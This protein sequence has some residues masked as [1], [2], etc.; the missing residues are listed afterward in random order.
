MKIITGF[1]FLFFSFVIIAQ[2]PVAWGGVTPLSQGKD[3]KTQFPNLLSLESR[4]TLFY[5]Y[6]QSLEKSFPLSLQSSNAEGRT[7]S[8][9]VGFDKERVTGG[10]FGDNCLWQYN[11]SARVILFELEGMTVLQAHP[12]GRSRN[13]VDDPKNCSEE[14]RDKKRDRFRFCQILL[15][16]ETDSKYSQEEVM[17]SCEN[18][19]LDDLGNGM[20]KEVGNIVANLDISDKRNIRFAGIG[21]VNITDRAL[22][23]L[24]GKEGFVSHPFHSVGGQFDKQSY[25]DWISQY[26][27][28]AIS[29]KLDVPLVAPFAGGLGNS[30]FMTLEDGSDVVL[31]LPE[32][33]YSFDILIRGFA[34]SLVDETAQ[35]EAW[36][37]GSYLTVD[38]GGMIGKE[39]SKVKNGY[40]FK[41]VKD[42][43]LNDWREFD[44]SVQQLAQE[45][46]DQLIKTDKKWVP[47]HT[48]M[49]YKDGKKYF[50]YI[51]EKLD[52][53]K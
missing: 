13:Y 38:F 35:R 5:Q 19:Q 44:N 16:L 26:F 12:V 46:A 18:V 33:D 30:A 48:N 28:K 8:I 36:I 25:K 49:K 23:I 37:Y 31:T 6:V 7:K 50:S 32:L 17:K 34:K 45:Y 9:V 4:Y 24:S 2:E 29:T 10:K 42:D 3:Q 39:S 22:G 15:G 47:Q 40:V 43:F 27:V 21:D 41:T 53:A 20:I 51:K 1:L 14:K 52:S 11:L